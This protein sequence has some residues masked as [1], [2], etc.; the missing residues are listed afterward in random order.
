MGGIANFMCTIYHTCLMFTGENSENCCICRFEETCFHVKP[1]IFYDT[2]PAGFY[3]FKV[4]NGNPRTMFEI[5]AKLFI[6]KDIRTGSVT[7][8]GFVFCYIWANFANSSGVSIVEFEQV[9]TG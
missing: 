5:C 4:H 6:Y 1:E 3:L 2:F 8:F 7:P 9:N